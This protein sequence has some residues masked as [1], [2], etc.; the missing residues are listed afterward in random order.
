M[1][2]VLLRGD[3][4]VRRGLWAHRQAGQE[5]LDPAAG[6]GSKTC[7]CMG[8]NGVLLSRSSGQGRRGWRATHGA[9]WRPWELAASPG[10][11]AK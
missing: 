10:V 1:D 6:W 2:C 9:R 11:R 5:V 7:V 3:T 8:G 4:E